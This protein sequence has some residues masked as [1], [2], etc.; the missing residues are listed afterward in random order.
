MQIFL[1]VH[2][3][4]ELQKYF[5]PRRQGVQ[6]SCKHTRHTHTLAGTLPDKTFQNIQT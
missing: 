6:S 5:V 1:A 4:S 3:I 2:F